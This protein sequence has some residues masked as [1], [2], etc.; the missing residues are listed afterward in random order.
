MR[1]CRPC[2]VSR[3]S[4]IERW[5]RTQSSR[6]NG[7][8]TL[9][10]AH[11]LHESQTVGTFNDDPIAA[12][13]GC[14][15]L[16]L[17]NRLD[18]PQRAQIEPRLPPRFC[19]IGTLQRGIDG[20][21]ARSVSSACQ[22]H[23]RNRRGPA[24]FQSCYQFATSDSR[25][26]HTWAGSPPQRRGIRPTAIPVFKRVSFKPTRGLEPRTPSLRVKCSTS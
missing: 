3:I 23:A 12:G 6:R 24:T 16:C 15:G 14:S 13:I 8:S 22:H 17:P 2:R 1:R 20:T 4:C 21:D 19:I 5:M 11:V 26:E 7:S 9:A 18:S 25:D 10:L